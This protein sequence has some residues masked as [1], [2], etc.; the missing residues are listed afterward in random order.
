LILDVVAAPTDTL[1]NQFTATFDAKYKA[2]QQYVA[3]STLVAR[4]AQL[5]AHWTKTLFIPGSP[6]FTEA[7][8]QHALGASVSLSERDGRLSGRYEFD[9]DVKN[10]SI[11]Y[12]R[13]LISYN[14]QCCGISADYKTVSRGPFAFLP[15]NRTFNLMFT[16]AGIGTFANPL[17]AFG[18]NTGR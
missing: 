5:S 8:T 6:D 12:Q 16:L 18:D 14:T 1:R 9:L 11:I 15:A 3:R 2:P 13:V 4:Q 10:R 17:G 7:R